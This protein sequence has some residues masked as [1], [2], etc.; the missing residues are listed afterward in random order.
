MTAFLLAGPLPS[1]KLAPCI[2]SPK[3]VANALARI[4]EEAE[5]PAAYEGT[6]SP[7]THRAGFCFPLAGKI[8]DSDVRPR[9]AN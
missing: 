8:W 2:E 6:A 5:F 7:G 9:I 4:A 3:P 1:P